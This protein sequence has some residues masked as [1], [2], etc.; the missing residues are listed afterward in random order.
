MLAQSYSPVD[1]R[2]RAR[3]GGA[4]RRAGRARPRRRASRRCA[5]RP[6][7]RTGAHGVRVHTWKR[8]RRAAA[9]PGRRAPPRAA[10][11]GPRDGPR[12]AQGPARGAAR[13]GARAQLASPSYLPLD[14]RSRPRWRSRLHDY[15]LLCATKRLIHRGLCSGPGPPKCVRCAA[16]ITARQGPASPSSPDSPRGG[17]RRHVDIFLP[18]SSAGRDHSRLR[19]RGARPG[20][21]QLHPR[22]P[23]APAADD[24]S[25]PSCRRALHPLL[26]RPAADKGTPTC[27]TPSSG[28]TGPPPLVLVGRWISPSRRAHPA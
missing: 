25:W 8:H 24:P 3:R 21:A 13:G 17:V 5:S 20:R 7:S 19:P 23:P 4:Q 18:V 16:I 14:R 26:R 15:G 10:A 9:A 28:W 27:S 11:A 12:P 2:R 6:E 22:A 1:R